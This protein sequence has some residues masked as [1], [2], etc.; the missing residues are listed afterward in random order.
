MADQAG[1]RQKPTRRPSGPDGAGAVDF[2]GAMLVVPPLDQNGQVAAIEVLLLD[3]RH[4]MANWWAMA[5]GKV[6]IAAAQFEERA[7]AVERQ[8]FR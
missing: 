3:P 7:R 8:A 1:L 2:G 4:D 5:K 6:D